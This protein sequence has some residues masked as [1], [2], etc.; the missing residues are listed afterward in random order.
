M[1][2]P[3][4]MIG[5]PITAGGAFAAAPKGTA[6]PTDA[7]AEVGAEFITR[8][9]IGVDGFTLAPNR[10]QSDLEVWGGMT[11]RRLTTKYSEILTTTFME[12]TNADTLKAVFGEDNVVVSGEGKIAISHNAQGPGEMAWVVTMKDGDARRRVAI[13]RGE[14]FLTGQI[15]YVHTDAIKYTVEIACYEDE[16]G[17]S[18]YEYI[19]DTATVPAG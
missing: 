5:S 16:A 11:A 3:E 12:S 6:L 17:Q 1:A 19:D 13:P 4:I 14:L 9:L 8:G 2:L 7:T 10:D 15:Q 18:S